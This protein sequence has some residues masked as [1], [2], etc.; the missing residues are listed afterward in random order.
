MS[1]VP[2]VIRGMRWGSPLG[3]VNVE[4]WLWDGLEDTNVGC[5]MAETAENLAKKYEHIP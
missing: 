5:T 2:H 1:Q 3:A 4:D